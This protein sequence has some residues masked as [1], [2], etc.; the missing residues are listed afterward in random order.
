MATKPT[1]IYSGPTTF[2]AKSLDELGGLLDRAVAALSGAIRRLS[3]GGPRRW[4]FGEILR[5]NGNVAPNVA[6][7][8]D[9][10]STPT[11]ILT[12]APPDS[13][14]IGL[15]CGIVRLSAAGTVTLFPIDGATLNGATTSAAL[16]A[17]AGFYVLV[18]RSGG[19]W[20]RR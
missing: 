7:A 16:T 18:I 17:T 11:I 13:R 9:T 6:V 20:L 2:R 10:Q 3:D 14:D 19:Y 4:V 1:V 5:G 15:E 8:C 12:L